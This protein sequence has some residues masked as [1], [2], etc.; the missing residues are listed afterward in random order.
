MSRP[1]GRPRTRPPKETTI[2]KSGKKRST[3]QKAAIVEGVRKA[4]AERQTFVEFA[5]NAL[6]I[7]TKSGTL[8]NFALNDVQ[9]RLHRMAESQLKRIGK[10]RMLVLKARQPGISTYVEG[11]FFWKTI[12]GAGLRAFILTHEEPASNNLFEMAKRFYEH[13]PPDGRPELAAANAREL[14]FAGRDCSYRVGTAGT[15]GIGRSETIQLF[16]GSEVARWPNADSHAAGVLQAVPNADGT[17]IWLEST[18]AGPAG[19]FYTMCM[20]AQEGIGE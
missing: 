14:K 17:E 11:R 2:G 7:R 16:H 9:G 20:R 5:A 19:L 10:V 8:Q 3:E 12:T 15:E 1:R 4:S 13:Y 6:T 18:A